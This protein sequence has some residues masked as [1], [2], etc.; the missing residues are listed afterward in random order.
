MNLLNLFS[1]K[2]D[3]VSAIV[4][5]FGRLWSGFLAV[6]EVVSPTER[7]NSRIFKQGIKPEFL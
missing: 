7:L 1:E 3:N 2:G 6:G 5:Y 4:F